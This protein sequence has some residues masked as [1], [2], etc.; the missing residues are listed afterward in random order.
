MG[1]R[2]PKPPTAAE[3]PTPPRRRGS[4]TT[5]HRPARPSPSP[6]AK[7]PS[8]GT[9]TF[10]HTYTTGVALPDKDT[11]PASPSGGTLPSETVTHDYAGAMDVPVSMGGL[12]AYTSNVTATPDGQVAQAE[13]GLNQG[14]HA[15]ITNTYDPHTNAL[16]DTQLTNDTVSTT[17]PI[18]ETTYTYDPVGNPTSQTETR[19]GST[20]ETQCFRYDALDRLN[21]AW[22]ATDNCTTDP[23][24]NNGATV[25]SGI[26]GGAYWTTWTLDPL[27][28]RTKQ[29]QH[30][31]A[32]TAD[33]VT[34]YTY[35]TSQ[36]NTLA[37][38]ST[39]G[40]NGAAVTSY[41][42]DPTGNTTTRT[43]PDQG[44]Q[45]LTWS[46]TGQLT[47]VTS[48][49]SNSNYIY[50]A[51]GNLLLQK[52]PGTTTLYLPNEQIALDTTTGTITGTRFY[53]LPGG[54]EAVRTGSGTA[55]SY[56]LTDRHNTGNLALDATLT[57]P[58]WRQQ[59]PYGNP[60]GTQPTNWPDNHGFLNK[61]QDTNTDL[62]DIGARWYDPSTARFTS[63]DPVFDPTS[64]QEQNGYTYAAANP[65]TNSDPT[66]LY[67][68]E[69]NSFG[70]CGPGSTGGWWR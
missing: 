18:D 27:G 8:A 42:Y 9:Y 26:A 41:G 50:D 10:T 62:T 32:G 11:Y 17:T 61:P 68:P 69:G 40:P 13:L 70:E 23:A 39:T 63:T 36:P 7:A 12:A 29:T 35:N 58:T 4:T 48:D 5:A 16:K 3:T 46:D 66:G 2:P 55:Y 15:Y 44:Q 60:R 49:S 45:T 1:N 51:D 65:I 28:Q 14:N 24:D 47:A 30:G 59:D 31:L 54:G 21:Q 34:T 43:T 33:T 52:D 25:G 38:T 6:E 19:Q 57:T 56:E 67:I 64:P 20:P 53:D 37:S 22:T